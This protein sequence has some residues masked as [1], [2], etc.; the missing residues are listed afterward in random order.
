M[1]QAI[2]KKSSLPAP[3]AP[4]R[5]HSFT[6]HGVTIV[7]DY[8][9]LKDKDWQEVLR[10][11]SVLN[12]DIRLYLEAENDYTDS[13]LRPYRR[14]QKDPGQGNA[15]ADQGGRFQ[16]AR[17]GWPYAYMRKFHEGGQHE[18]F[19]RTRA[20]AARSRS[21]STAI[22]LRRTMNTSGSAAR[23]IRDHR[24]EAWS[25]DIKGRNIYDSRPRLENRRRPRRRRRGDRRRGGVGYRLQELLLRKARRQPP[26]DA[27]LASSPWEQRRRTMFCL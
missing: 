15:R 9:W 7:D 3:V 4:R 10:D 24:L 12:A 14:L 25:A 6:V 11:P 17:A 27:G 23:G 8:A 26:P 1:T 5:P 18:M 19:G 16:R 2:R 22:S 20:M 21:C 13:L